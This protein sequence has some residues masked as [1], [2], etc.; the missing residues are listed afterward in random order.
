MFVI[1]HPHLN[2]DL[3]AVLGLVS[4]IATGLGIAYIMAKRYLTNR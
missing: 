3:L 1:L 4:G 2:A